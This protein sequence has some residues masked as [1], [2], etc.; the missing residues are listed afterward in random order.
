MHFAMKLLLT[1]APGTGKTTLAR[2]IAEKIPEAAGFF[3]EEIRHGR[4]RVGFRIVN[5]PQGTIRLLAHTRH[6][7]PR[8]GKYG[9]V[10]GAIE[11]AIAEVPNDAPLYVIDEIGKMEC[12]SSRFLNWII[13]LLD[14]ETPLLAT[15]ALHAGGFIEEIKSRPDVELIEL[16]RDHHHRNA[17]AIARSL[18]QRIG[19]T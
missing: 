5:I 4:T 16:T 12:L 1:G 15:I 7:G 6:K 18:L 14:S 9:V 10:Q 3:T 11:E 17:D 2:R 13:A 19:P 8:I